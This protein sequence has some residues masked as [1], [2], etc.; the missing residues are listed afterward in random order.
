MKKINIHAH[1]APEFDRFVLNTP[2]EMLLTA[3]EK[4]YEFYGLVNHLVF[5]P[6]MPTTRRNDHIYSLDCETILPLWQKTI[7]DIRSAAAKIDIEVKVGFEVDFFRDTNWRNDFERIVEKLD[8][9]YLICGIHF[10]SD[11]CGDK[12]I[13]MYLHDMSR[14]DYEYIR[15]NYFGVIKDA[16]KSGYFNCIAHL[17]LI[18]Y[19]RP[20]LEARITNDMCE[21]AELLSDSKTLTE[22]NTS[23]VRKQVTSGAK[24]DYFPAK[25]YLPLLKD[26][27]VQMVISDDAHSANVIGFDYEE[28]EKNLIDA[29]ITN[30]LTDVSTL[31]RKI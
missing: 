12:L 16:I 7:A 15:Q 24:P 28:A 17:D 19:M 26:C 2:Q 14:L 20:D 4:G 27:N 5:H 13:D 25:H 21:V 9:D 6:Q 1:G 23:G 22:I 8:Y 30:R 3:K 10:L 29:G 31:K 11:A 18:R